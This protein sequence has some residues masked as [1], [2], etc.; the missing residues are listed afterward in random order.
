MGLP[1]VRVENQYEG[2]P[3]VVSLK[4]QLQ[5]AVGGGARVVVDGEGRKFDLVVKPSLIRIGGF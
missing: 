2:L 1:G 3:F 4:D 5:A